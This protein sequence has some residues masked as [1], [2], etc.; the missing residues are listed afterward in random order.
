[1][2]VSRESNK[3]TFF[4]LDSIIEINSDYSLVL[5]RRHAV[6]VDTAN[7]CQLFKFL[8]TERTIS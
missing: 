8:R 6:I 2:L 1:M 3:A 7:Y 4:G 5:N